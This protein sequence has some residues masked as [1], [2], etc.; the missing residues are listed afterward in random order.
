MRPE[1]TM[2]EWYRAGEDYGR[3]MEDCVVLAAA[4]GGGGG[5]GGAAVPGAE[6]RSLS[7]GPERLSVAE[8]VRCA[9]RAWT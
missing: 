9:M 7:A 1:F 4:R 3:L 2:L 6:L 8:A 5:G